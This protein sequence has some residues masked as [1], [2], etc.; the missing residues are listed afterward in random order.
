MKKKEEEEDEELAQLL[1]YSYFIQQTCWTNICIDSPPWTLQ[2]AASS[3]LN[4]WLLCPAWTE[5]EIESDNYKGNTAL[6]RKLA[7]T[8]RQ[9]QKVLVRVYT[10]SNKE[11][12]VPLYLTQHTLKH[13]DNHNLKEYLTFFVGGKLKSTISTTTT[14]KGNKALSDKS[15]ECARVSNCR[16]SA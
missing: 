15:W 8:K 9:T 4:G 1:N 7:A 13:T 6:E 5:R 10:W 16:S 12:G 14:T 11:I 2:S 3:L